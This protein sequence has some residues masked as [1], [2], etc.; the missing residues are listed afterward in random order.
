MS[1]ASYTSHCIAYAILRIRHVWIDIL[2]QVSVLVKVA[3]YVIYY[4]FSYYL[5]AY[6]AIKIYYQSITQFFKSLK[7]AF[8]ARRITFG[9]VR[10]QEPLCIIMSTLLDKETIHHTHAVIVFM[11]FIRGCLIHKIINTMSRRDAYFYFLLL[12]IVI[13]SNLLKVT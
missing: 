6:A 10:G 9:Y 13:S 12:F 1:E 11:N 5:L 4:C 2:F 7:L 8:F 3:A